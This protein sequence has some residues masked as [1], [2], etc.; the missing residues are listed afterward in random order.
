[1]SNFFSGLFKSF[2]DVPQHHL[3]EYPMDTLDQELSRIEADAQDGL[4]ANRWK[5]LEDNLFGDKN[6]ILEYGG[7]FGQTWIAFKDDYNIEYYGIELKPVADIGNNFFGKKIFFDYIP[8]KEEL[9]PLDIIY[10]RE[11]MQYVEDF[12]KVVSSFIKLNPRRI[13]FEHIGVTDLEDFWTIQHYNNYK[14]P[15]H[16][17]NFNDLNNYIEN[18]Q[19]SLTSKQNIEYNLSEMIHP[20]LRDKMCHYYVNLTYERVD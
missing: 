7:S 16:F 6:I 4:N 11:A 17:F 20:D 2:N 3:T 19:Y 18:S 8:T 13:I 14:L 15:W 10:T 9:P 5:L 12:E 1:M